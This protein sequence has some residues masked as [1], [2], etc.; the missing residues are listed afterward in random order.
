MACLRLKSWVELMAPVMQADA[1]RGRRWEHRNINT[2]IREMT[3]S[4]QLTL[5]SLID[6]QG[7]A[8]FKSEL[9]KWLRA[10]L[11]KM[12]AGIKT[13]LLVA[14]SKISVDMSLWLRSQEGSWGVRVQPFLVWCQIQARHEKQ[15]LY[16]QRHRQYIKFYNLMCTTWSLLFKF[17]SCWELQNGSHRM[18]G[19]SLDLLRAQGLESLCE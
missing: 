11:R 5:F 19:A 16:S 13:R 10:S 12:L 4:Q 3:L 7:L 17:P 18:R 6:L 14:T 1:S 2:A 15:F 9:W 8:S